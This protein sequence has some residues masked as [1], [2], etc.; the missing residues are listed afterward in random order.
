MRF[1]SSSYMIPVGTH[2]VKRLQIAGI[3]IEH[4]VS[5]LTHNQR[6]FGR[7]PGLAIEDWLT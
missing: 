4:N 1:M 3:A 7:V 2:P 5:L 6:H